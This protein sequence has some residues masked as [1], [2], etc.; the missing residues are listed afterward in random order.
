MEDRI[1]GAEDEGLVGQDASCE[2]A[3]GQLIPLS[4]NLLDCANLSWADGTCDGWVLCRGAWHW[5]GDT[6]GASG[7]LEHVIANHGSLKADLVCTGIP[8]R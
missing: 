6:L 5:V 7:G 4:G 3:D 1:V 8:L 2:A